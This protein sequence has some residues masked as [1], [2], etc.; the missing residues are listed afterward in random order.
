MPNI[1]TH[2][3]FLFFF[4]KHKSNEKLKVQKRNELKEKENRKIQF[5]YS[6]HVIHNFLLSFFF[7]TL[8]Y[9]YNF[10]FIS[11]LTY[12]LFKGTDLQNI[13]NNLLKAQN[14]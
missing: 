2:I 13:F 12:L 3:F 1:I 10:V 8:V 9:F 6:L 7:F 14:Q 4:D 11:I 5:V